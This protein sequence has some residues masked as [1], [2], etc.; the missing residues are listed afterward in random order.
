MDRVVC[1]DCGVEYSGALFKSRLVWDVEHLPVEVKDSVSCGEFK[2]TI[3]A[4]DSFIFS[5]AETASKS[6][7]APVGFGVE[8]VIV[9]RGWEERSGVNLLPKEWGEGVTVL[10]MDVYCVPEWA[11]GGS[12]YFGGG[13]GRLFP[14]GF[15]KTPVVPERVEKSLVGGLLERVCFRELSHPSLVGDVSVLTVV[16]EWVVTTD[17]SVRDVIFE[18]PDHI[19]SVGRRRV[20]FPFSF[21]DVV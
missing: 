15:R 16:E 21:S 20:I 9:L 19:S 11:L 7:W 14:E 4:R 5:R 17:E 18:D 2:Y 8:P 13:R 1:L 10:E 3:Q 12:V 6:W